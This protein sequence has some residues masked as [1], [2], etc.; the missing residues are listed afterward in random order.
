[1]DYSEGIAPRRAP[2]GGSTLLT[3]IPGVETLTKR[4]RCVFSPIG[5]NLHFALLTDFPDADQESL[6]TDAPLLQLARD[7]ISAL[8]RTYGVDKEAPETFSICCIVRAAGIRSSARGWA[9]S[10]S[11]ASSRT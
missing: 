6:P 3:D 9:V 1:M 5:V 2:W 10:A 8:N 7:G 11:E 4:S